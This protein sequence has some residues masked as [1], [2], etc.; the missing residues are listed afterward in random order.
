MT[1]IL[2]ADPS[3]VVRAG[4][5]RLLEALPDLDVVAEAADGQDAILKALA[6]RP[7]VA[8]VEVC[9]PGMDGIE[10]AECVRRRL[11]GTEVL[12]FTQQQD[13]ASV[14]QA[15]CA[16][17]RGYVFKSDP[18]H[19]L[20]EAIS[21]LSSHRPYFTD[22]VAELLLRSLRARKVGRD[23]NGPRVGAARRG[24]PDAETGVSAAG[25]G[26]IPIPPANVLPE[27]SGSPAMP[28]SKRGSGA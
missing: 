2:I 12:V 13:E 26:A 15:L 3:E 6:C 21:S 7:D 8:V 25:R 14:L 18:G 17:A 23:A 27:A 5:G 11:P 19:C 22:R 4:V 20:V 28:G 1:R 10:V 24:L 16:G 9:L